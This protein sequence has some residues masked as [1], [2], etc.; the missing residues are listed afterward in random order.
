[1]LRFNGQFKGLEW[2]TEKRGN[3]VRTVAIVYVE[4]PL[5]LDTVHVAELEQEPV[6]VT[7][8]N[9]EV[10]AVV[11]AV[12]KLGD[13]RP[14]DSHLLLVNRD[15]NQDVKFKIVHDANDF[16]PDVVGQFAQLT[17][18][19][20]AQL[21]LEIQPHTPQLKLFGDDD[22]DDDEYTAGFEA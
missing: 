15:E 2:K 14:V 16:P 4:T 9:P 11:E 20:E 3:N 21:S 22:A 12:A 8:S 1:M 10:S 6:F 17:L 18:M 5:P 7:Y 19:P 13:T